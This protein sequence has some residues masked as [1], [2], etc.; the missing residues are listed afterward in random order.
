MRNTCEK[1]S[2]IKALYKHR[3]KIRNLSDKQNIV[4]MNQDK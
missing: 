2:E 1:Y 3:E 4:K